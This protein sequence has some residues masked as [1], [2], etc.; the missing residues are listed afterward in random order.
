MVKTMTKERSPRFPFVPLRA[1]LKHLEKVHQA[2]EADGDD[3]TIQRLAAIQ[4]LG[5]DKPNGKV[6]R[7]FAAMR[8]YGL[9]DAVKKGTPVFVVT[10]LGKRLLK[11]PQARAN[12][13]WLAAAREAVL[14]PP[15]FRNIWNRGRD[16]DRDQLVETLLQR[17]FTEQGAEKA[18]AVFTRN[19]Q[20]AGLDDMPEGMEPPVRQRPAA[21]KKA[22]RKAARRALALTE[23][24]GGGEGLFA[25]RRPN[26]PLGP[27]RDAVV[28][29]LGNKRAII[30]TGISQDDYDL[31]VETLT[32]WKGK[33]VKAD[34]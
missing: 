19:R 6:H 23:Q 22:A 33:I 11:S 32:L 16:L 14:N 9:L 29:P 1:A 7:L 12:G 4:A 18:A 13:P 31:L 34:G 5:Y 21:A 8:G 28:L 15:L 26:R 17:D 2:A 24:G 3:G 25:P 10:S 30:P 20:I 27:P